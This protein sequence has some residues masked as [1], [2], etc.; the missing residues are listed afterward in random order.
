M[1][2][3]VMEDQPFILSDDLLW[4]YTDGLLADAEHKQLEAYLAEHPDWMARL[5][6]VEAD[7]RLLQSIPLETPP[8]GF[9][10]AVMGAWNGLS[11]PPVES[12]DW[13]IRGIGVL[14]GLFILLPLGL[15][16]FSGLRIKNSSF[17]VPNMPNVDWLALFSHPVLQY[18]LYF[19]FTLLALRLLS[20]VLA[21]YRVMHK[22]IV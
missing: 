2:T 22:M 18:G 21:Q 12:P 8:Q 10:T 6:A 3:R 17:S 11:T 14:F 13:V 9:A 19:G 1:K 4:D 15:M 16:I 20:A 5:Q 7:R